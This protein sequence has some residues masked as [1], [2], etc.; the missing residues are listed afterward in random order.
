MKDELEAQQQPWSS[1][2]ETQQ[3]QLPMSISTLQV[4]VE[5]TL[6]SRLCYYYGNMGSMPKSKPVPMDCHN[7]EPIRICLYRS[8][9]SPKDPTKRCLEHFDNAAW[10]PSTPIVLDTS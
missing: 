3:A 10:S 8:S 4:T 7:P 6:K 5:S 1:H 2:W 9:A